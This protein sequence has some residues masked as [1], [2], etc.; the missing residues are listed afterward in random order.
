MKV[1]LA[2]RVRRPRRLER[3]GWRRAFDVSLAAVLAAYVVLWAWAVMDAVQRG[4]RPAISARIATNP[5]DPSG[6]PEAAFLL[7]AALRLLFRNIVEPAT[8]E[9]GAVRVV[10]AAPDSAPLTPDSLPEGVAIEYRAV[11]DTTMRDTAHVPGQPGIWDMVVS[12]RNAIRRVPNLR[13]ISLVPISAKRGG[14]IG[15]YRVGNWPWEEGGTPRSPAYA[16]PRGLIP[17]HPEDVD[18]PVSTH[19]TLGDFLT[20]GQADVWP[21]YVLL[22]PRLLD[23]LELTIQQLERMGHPVENV[24]VISGFRT[25]QYNE[26]G[27]DPSGRGALSRHMY[28]DA[29][30]FFIDNDG[31]GRMD[32][33]NGDGSVDSDDGRVMIEAGER[34][35]QR[36][37]DLIGGLGLYAPTGAHA[38]FV[39][40]DTRGYRARW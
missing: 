40:T 33:L 35:E 27:G 8:G 12:A 26:S 3:P 31:D 1:E 7:D 16:P 38:G 20:K 30:D 5:L 17:V 37:P 21:K 15:D 6:P 10:I 24:G 18:I 11:G 23:K 19:F 14:Y 2:P 32:D 28:G 29:M 36:Y 22:S 25:P 4:A 34:V 13:V 39:H 9:S